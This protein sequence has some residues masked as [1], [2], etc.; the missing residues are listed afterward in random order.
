MRAL[1][2]HSG[3]NR[4]DPTSQDNVE[5]PYG[6]VELIYQ[7]GFEFDVK[8]IIQEGLIAGGKEGSQV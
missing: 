8:S 2:G 1:L 3:G 6:W 7:V 5:I 4:V